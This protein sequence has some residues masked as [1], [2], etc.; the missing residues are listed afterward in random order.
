MLLPKD[1]IQPGM[2]Y[3][4]SW[5]EFD[6]NGDNFIDKYEWMAGESGKTAPWWARLGILRNWWIKPTVWC[7]DGCIREIKGLF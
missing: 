5:M 6:L 4:K 1:S 2:E 7:K 3:E